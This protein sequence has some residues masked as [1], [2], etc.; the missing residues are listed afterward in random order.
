L[1]SGIYAGD[2]DKMSLMS[3]FPQFAEMEKQYRSLI[4]AMKTMRPPKPTATKPKGIFLTLKKGLHSMVKAIEEQL[5]QVNVIKGKPLKLVKKNE[6]GYLLHLTQEKPLQADTIIL[7]DAIILAT[8]H[9]VT[10]QVLGNADFLEPLHGH[11]VS[12]ATVILAF[13]K[14]AVHLTKEGTG[15]VVPRTEPYTITACTWT[16]KKWPHTAPPGKA[17]LRCYVGRAGD[18]EIV[19][20]PDDEIVDMVIRDL[21]RVFPITDNPD[22]TFV[23]RWKSAM[24]QFVVGHQAW[25]KQLNEKMATHYPGIF[26]AGS[27]YAGSGIP[28]CID[29]G[30]KAVQDVLKYLSYDI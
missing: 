21:K 19:D 20:K 2:I 7:A 29:Q 9:R 16:H 28:D 14:N 25:L 30:I 17:L 22:F 23:T 15:F 6:Q 13:P 8:P 5:T 4:L 27:S 24:P 3:T 1:L 10:R 26:L 11:P 18:E 12:V